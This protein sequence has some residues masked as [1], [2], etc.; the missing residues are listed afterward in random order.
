[1]SNDCGSRFEFSFGDL[2]LPRPSPLVWTLAGSFGATMAIALVGA[3]PAFAQ[4]AGTSCTVT[5]SSDD[6]GG[7]IANQ[8]TLR[9]AIAYA[10]ANAGTTVGFSSSLANATIALGAALPA[11]N[12]NVT[13][14]GSGASGL[15]VSGANASRVFF[16]QSGTVTIANMTIANGS[17][18]GGARAAGWAPAAAAAAW[19]RRGDFRQFRQH[20]DVG[21]DLFQ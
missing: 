14:D 10:N 1:M 7:S 3:S 5:T 16:V 2:R 18:Q 17:A 9:D 6:A 12:A 21:R 20:H 8:T 11:I 15:T 4:C 19:G 13:I